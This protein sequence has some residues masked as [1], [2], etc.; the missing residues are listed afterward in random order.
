MKERFGYD[1]DKS[2]KCSNFIGDTID[3]AK[4][5]GFSKMLLTGHIGKLIKLSGGMM[6]T[7]SKEGDCR[8]ELLCAAAVRCGACAQAARQILDCVTTEEGVRVLE[9]YQLLPQTMQAVMEKIL[10]Y[11]NKRAGDALQIE[12]ILYSNEHGLL[13]MSSGAEQFLG[14]VH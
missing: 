6:N 9:E 10:F 2:I 3:M 13:A 14:T 12:C 7:H 4:Q 8:M 5:I 1:L 11:L